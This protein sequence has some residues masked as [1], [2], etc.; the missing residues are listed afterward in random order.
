MKFKLKTPLVQPSVPLCIP[1][2]I[3]STLFNVGP[4]V[5]GIVEDGMNQ[6]SPY[7]VSYTHLTLP[8]KRIV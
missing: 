7:S 6:I 5:G 4:I 8:T 1:E 3:M 2:D